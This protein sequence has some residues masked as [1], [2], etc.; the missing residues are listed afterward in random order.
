[1][2][3]C[4]FKS[5]E[6]KKKYLQQRETKFF[7]SK[8][9]KILVHH[10]LSGISPTK[11]NIISQQQSFHECNPIIINLRCPTKR[12]LSHFAH[13]LGNAEPPFQSDFMSF[14]EAKK[15]GMLKLR[16]RKKFNRDEFVSLCREIRCVGYYQIRYLISLIVDGNYQS[17]N[18]IMHDWSDEQVLKEFEKHMRAFPKQSNIGVSFLTRSGELR[19]NSNA[20]KILDAFGLNNFKLQTHYPETR[21]THLIEGMKIDTNDF[22]SASLLHSLHKE[23][24]LLGY[25]FGNEI[26]S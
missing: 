17:K 16:Q 24:E 14:E 13:F 2:I 21:R 18:T 20:K 1:M 3:S 11:G 23:E 22:F 26:L 6:N 9:S 10:H 12:T 8:F 25:T 5:H 15:F 4:A 7:D 19:L